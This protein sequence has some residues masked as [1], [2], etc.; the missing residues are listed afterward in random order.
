MN[1]Y[2]SKH[3][4]GFALTTI[5]FILAVVALLGGG[6]YYIANPTGEREDIISCSADAKICPDGSSVERI[7]PNCEFDAC[8]GEVPVLAAQEKDADNEGTETSSDEMSGSITFLGPRIAGDENGSQLLEFNQTDYDNAISADKLVL[9]YFFANWCPICKEEFEQTKKAFDVLDDPGVVGF[10]VNYKDSETTKDEEAI[11][12][13]HG[14]AY[15]HTK[16]FVR[17]DRRLKK[18]P[19][20]YPTVEHYIS[21]IKQVQSIK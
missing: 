8:P 4:R 19:E 13:E 16:V 14:V 5:L 6:A 18:S 9:L 20:G 17:G 2:Q 21:T 1:V 12:R 11:A 15:Q 10:R 3:E 7:G